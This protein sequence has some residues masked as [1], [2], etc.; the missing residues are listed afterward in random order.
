MIVGQKER[1]GV[2]VDYL[3]GYLT[4]FLFSIDIWMIGEGMTVWNWR[5][6]VW[7]CAELT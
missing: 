3:L 6:S 1:G 5:V 7:V 2:V 4:S